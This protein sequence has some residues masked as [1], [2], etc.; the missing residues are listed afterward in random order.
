MKQGERRRQQADILITNAEITSEIQAALMRGETL[1]P[2]EAVQRIHARRI[3]FRRD[4]GWHRA[5]RCVRERQ[6]R[7]AA[8]A[9]RAARE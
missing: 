3:E 1:T 4:S 2:T 5:V 6:A 7:Q 9:A 8:E